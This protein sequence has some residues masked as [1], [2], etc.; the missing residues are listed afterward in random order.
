MA[1]DNKL[2]TLQSGVLDIRTAL[3]ECDQSLAGGAIN[4]LA[5][6]IRNYYDRNNIIILYKEPSTTTDSETGEEVTTYTYKIAKLEW[7]GTNAPVFYDTNKVNGKIVACIFPSNITNFLQN[8]TFKNETDLEYVNL[9]SFTQIYGSGS[10]ENCTS[11]KTITFPPEFTYLQSS[12]FK[13]CSSLVSIYGFE[14]ISTIGNYCFSGCSKLSEIHVSSLEGFLNNNFGTTSTSYVKH[15]FTSSIAE[16]RGLYINRELVTN[17]E[18]PSTVTKING[19][20]FYKNNTIKSV[21]VSNSVTE[22]ENYAFADC[23]SIEKLVIPASVS[24][25]TTVIY[26]N[27]GS[28]TGVLD[29]H[30]QKVSTVLNSNLHYRVINYYGDFEVAGN[31][32]PFKKTLQILRIKGSFS[33]TPTSSFYI[34]ESRPTIEFVEIMGDISLAYSDY[35][36]FYAANDNWMG[37]SVT[38]HLGYEGVVCK[39]IFFRVDSTRL[40]KL[41]VGDGSSASHDNTIL[42]QYL[43]DADW[44]QYSAKLDTWYNYI[45]SPDAN[46][47]YIN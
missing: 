10:F 17:I 22:I 3:K 13:G 35:S 34:T 27:S 2:Q 24:S 29:D 26:Q 43:A 47:D 30:R 33:E 46:P 18:I 11:L 28:T 42:Q 21:I 1:I 37:S 32:Q 8:N 44:A 6:D 7:N 31:H 5:N 45:N 36:F 39:P 38:A 4:T 25:G 9:D 19:W 40:V 41:L 14:N 16:S 15:P 20:S 12:S 23:T